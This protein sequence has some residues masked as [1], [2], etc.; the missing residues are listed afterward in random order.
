MEFIVAKVDEGAGYI[1]TDWRVPLGQNGWKRVGYEVHGGGL[2]API[3][4]K[5]LREAKAYI[6]RQGAG[7][8]R[9]F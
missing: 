3:R 6:T 5:L 1:I 4:F 7:K 9:P 2:E 8:E